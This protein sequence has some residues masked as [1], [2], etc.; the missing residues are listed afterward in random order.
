MGRLEMADQP[1]EVFGDELSS[2]GPYDFTS[3]ALRLTANP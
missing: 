3:H 2:E 1:N